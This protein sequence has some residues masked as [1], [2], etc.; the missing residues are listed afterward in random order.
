MAYLNNPHAPHKTPRAA[1]LS[2]KGLYTYKLAEKWQ[3]PTEIRD[4]NANFGTIAYTFVERKLCNANI[5]LHW[6]FSI[7][8]IS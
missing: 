7:T 6:D 2:S 1:F 3:K 5:Q 4:T 8:S